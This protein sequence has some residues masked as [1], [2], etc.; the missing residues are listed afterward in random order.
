MLAGERELA[1]GEV[2]GANGLEVLFPK[3]RELI[4]QLG[5]G[6]PAIALEMA[7]AVERD[8]PAIGSLHQD[9]A[10]P[11]NPVRFLAVDEVPHHVE[12]TP[13]AGVPATR[14]QDVWHVGQ[15]FVKHG[16]GSAEGGEGCFEIESRRC[17]GPKVQQDPRA[18]NGTPM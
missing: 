18:G 8:E 4:E 15:E 11:R 12:G 1:W 5:E 14:R 7:E 9:D 3:P 16:R 2:P 10:G 6:A 17:H 13:L